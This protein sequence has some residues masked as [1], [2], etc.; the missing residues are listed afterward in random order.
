M[1]WSENKASEYYQFVWFGSVWFLV[2]FGALPPTISRVPVDPVDLADISSSTDPFGISVVFY[3]QRNILSTILRTVPW[4]SLIGRFPNNLAHPGPVHRPIVWILYFV[5]FLIWTITDN[6]NPPLQFPMIS[7]CRVTHICLVVCAIE[8][9]IRDRVSCNCLVYPLSSWLMS[10]IS[11][12]G[13]MS[14]VCI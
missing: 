4:M 14:L 13:T 6:S 3:Q 10:F 5:P 11:T 12:L 2:R 7:M 9:S 1:T 8:M